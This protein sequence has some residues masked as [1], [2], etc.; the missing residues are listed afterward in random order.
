MGLIAGLVAGF[1]LCWWFGLQKGFLIKWKGQFNRKFWVKFP[2]VGQTDLRPSARLKGSSLG[3]SLLIPLRSD[4]AYP[5]QAMRTGLE[6]ALHSGQPLIFVVFLEVPRTHNLE[7]G[8]DDQ[9]EE[10]FIFL[11]RAEQEAHQAGVNIHT[12]ATK[13][14]NYLLGV[15]DSALELRAGLVI[16]EHGGE[17]HNPNRSGLDAQAN[18]LAGK[19]GCNILLVTRAT[20]QSELLPVRS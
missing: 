2:N 14:R 12:S 9:L 11:E 1:S 20:A 13:V 8:L 5:E 7:S 17:S 16:L 15:V 3:R 6:L 18:Q 4:M 19:T 10:A